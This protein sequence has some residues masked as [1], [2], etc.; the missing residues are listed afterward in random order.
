MGNDNHDE[1]GRFAAGSSNGAGGKS[2][3]HAGH[4]DKVPTTEQAAKFGRNIALTGDPKTSAKTLESSI[5]NL[6]PS[7]QNAARSA[8]QSASKS[9]ASEPRGKLFSG[10]QGPRGSSHTK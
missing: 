10:S 7:Q 1:H 8:Y 3:T 5:K 4:A 6:P 2:G 9:G